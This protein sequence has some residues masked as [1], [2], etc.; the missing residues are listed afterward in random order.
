MSN[1]PINSGNQP[2]TPQTPNAP[3]TYWK[4]ETWI[5][6]S[7]SGKMGIFKINGQ[8]YGVSIKLMKTFLS[9]TGEQKGIPIKIIPPN[10][11][12]QPTQPTQ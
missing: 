11:N 3:V 6:L 1:Q 5:N 7:K 4:T 9:E 12:Y 10:P 8:L 2:T